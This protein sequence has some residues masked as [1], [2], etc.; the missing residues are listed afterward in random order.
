MEMRRFT[1]FT[2]LLILHAPLKQNLAAEWT[3]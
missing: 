3:Q 2:Q 1:L